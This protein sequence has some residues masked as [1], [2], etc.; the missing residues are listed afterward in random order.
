MLVRVLRLDD[1]P[2]DRVVREV[3]RGEL[4]RLSDGEAV[5]ITATEDAGLLL[6]GGAPLNEPVSHYG[7]FVMNTKAEIDQAITDYQQGRLVRDPVTTL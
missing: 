3:D 5:H 6:F 2:D 7:P 4:A 1:E